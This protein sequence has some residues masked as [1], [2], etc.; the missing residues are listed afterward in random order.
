MGAAQGELLG[1]VILASS[2]LSLIRYRFFIGL[3]LLVLIVC[4]TRSVHPIWSRE[5]VSVTCQYIGV[6]FQ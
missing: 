1:S 5:N 6:V 4:L 2:I 3:S